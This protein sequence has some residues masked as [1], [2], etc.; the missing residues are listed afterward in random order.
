MAGTGTAAG[1]ASAAANAE[2]DKQG[3][4]ARLSAESAFTRLPT[5]TYAISEHV[6]REGTPVVLTVVGALL[7][8]SSAGGAWQRIT[9]VTTASASPVVTG[10]ELGA[11][12]ATGVAA[13]LAA[14]VCLVLARGWR[15][16]TRGQRSVAVATVLTVILA[17]VQLVTTQSDLAD[18][19]VQA[20]AFPDFVAR[21][22]GL[23][24]GAWAG[25]AGAC[26]LLL[27][28]ASGLLAVRERSV[29]APQ[30]PTTFGGRS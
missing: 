12:S 20:I 13:A 15:T 1:A 30:A 7:V 17:L 29:D 11:D 10:V 23:G 19:S 24:W 25:F 21:N 8:L 22:I 5:P 16:G 27:A 2:V 9:E 14:G 3:N 6:V 28:L 4:A 18:L 26:L